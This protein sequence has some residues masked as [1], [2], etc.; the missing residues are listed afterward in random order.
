MRK[1]R[2]LTFLTAFMLSAS[3][4]HADGI[5]IKVKGQWDFAFGWVVN[6]GFRTNR[7]VNPKDDYFGA[8][9][10]IRTQINFISSEYLQGV[11][12]FEIGDIDWGR[13][14]GGSARAGQGNGGGLDADG[15]NVET[16][17]AYLDWIIPHTDVSIRMGIQG[18]GLPMG[19]GW[20]NPVFSADVAGIVANYP[21]SEMFGI[22]AFWARPFDAFAND[23]SN[24]I[25]S[26]KNFSD[27]MDMFGLVLPITGD[28]WSVTPWGVYSLIG[29]ASGYF[30]YIAGIDGHTLGTGDRNSRTHA[31]WAG[32]STE[33]EI[34]DPLTFSVDAMYGRMH[35][36]NIGIWH[37]D[38]LEYD[39]S[40]RFGTSGWF[41]VAAL[42]YKLDWGTPGIYGWYA[43]GDSESAAR[44]G[45]YGRMPVVGVDDGFA[46]TTFGFP[47]S[48]GI[49]ADTAVSTTGVGTWGIAVQL[50]EVSFVEDLSHTLRFAYYRGTNDDEIIKKY[51]GYDDYVLKSGAEEI[52][53]TKKDYAFEVNFDHSY[54]IY[55]NLT[56]ILELGYIH[57]KLDSGTWQDHD[58]DDAW[59]A[60]LLF[61]YAF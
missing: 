30:D 17:R 61:Q 27:E 13:T 43:S 39:G 3:V 29:N 24:E 54:Q 51:G 28:G 9:Q 55:E 47:G 4:A 45:K 6:G 50:A 8:S 31:W 57:L 32:V 48:A 10:R 5:D 14:Y 19:N 49:G 12:M 11:L 16:K 22:T 25:F 20:D 40:M 18:L 1:W 56:A 35:K 7:D 53:M 21:I 58:T 41:V 44:D 36:T 15:V 37:E 33:I 23:E 42:N 52:Y 2:W 59:K 46:A 38:D 26:G 60:Q 34:F